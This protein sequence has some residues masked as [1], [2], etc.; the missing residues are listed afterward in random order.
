[1]SALPT[2]AGAATPSGSGPF[3]EKKRVIC[4]VCFEPKRGF[5]KLWPGPCSGCIDKGVA[6]ARV[7]EGIIEDIFA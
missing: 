7:E 2:T 4:P 3:L 5:Q 6:K 1:M